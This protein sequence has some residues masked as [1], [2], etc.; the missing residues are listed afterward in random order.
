MEIYNLNKIAAE[1][2]LVVFFLVQSSKY[3]SFSPRDVPEQCSRGAKHQ[4][5]LIISKH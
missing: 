3:N 4:N 1:F 5:S 2:R